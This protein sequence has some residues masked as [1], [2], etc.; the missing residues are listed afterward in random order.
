MRRLKRKPLTVPQQNLKIM[1]RY[2]TFKNY[3]KGRW[4]GTLRP[5]PSS[6]IYTVAI[7]YM[8]FRPRVYIISPEIDEYAPHLYPDN[9]L[10][11]YHPSDQS[12]HENLFIADTIIPWTAEWLYYYEKWL[13]DEVWWA[14]EAPH[15]P[16]KDKS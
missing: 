14:P 3:K 9:S 15:S 5:T 16:K 4:V 7:V 12:Y 2:P 6:P 8:K 13:E 11:L 10:C 1:Q